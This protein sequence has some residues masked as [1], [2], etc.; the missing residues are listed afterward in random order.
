MGTK[1]KRITYSIAGLIII[2]IVVM[3]WFF[4]YSPFSIHKSY[5]YQPAEVLYNGKTYE[6]ILNEFKDSYEKDLKTDLENDYSNLTIDRT[7]YILPIFE[8]DWLMNNGSVAIDKMK[9][10]NILWEVKEARELLLSLIVQVDYT[11][12]E[13]GYLVDLINHFY[14]LEENI[15]ELE[16]GGYISRKGIKR[17]LDN[18]YGELTFTFDFYVTF[19]ERSH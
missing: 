6:T 11:S 15:N 5:S 12:E 3:T 13:R 7:Q 19:Y 9:L 16:K 2:F 10:E 18:L 4:P 1:R 14:L 17:Q 8:Q